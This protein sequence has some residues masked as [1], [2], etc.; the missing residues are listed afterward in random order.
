MCSHASA[1][2][3]IKLLHTIVD[4][5]LH[6]TPQVLYNFTPMGIYKL[7]NLLNKI[8]FDHNLVICFS[9]SIY[10]KNITSDTNAI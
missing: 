9:T 2:S 6:T 1:T 7:R 5:E 3:Y 4:S 10:T 8:N